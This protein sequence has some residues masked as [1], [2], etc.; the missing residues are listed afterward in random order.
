MKKVLKCP[1]TDKQKQMFIET[2]LEM[3][4]VIKLYHW[5]TKV[6][7]IH[8]ATDDLRVKLEL[9][10]DRFT[11]ILIG[12]CHHRLKNVQQRINLIDI[13][14]TDSLKHKLFEYRG[15]L[16]DMNEILNKKSDTDLLSVRDEIL[17]DINQFLY[18][19]TFDK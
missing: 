3:T 14:T 10:T 8:K 9:N 2:F 1:C 17:G 13:K 11:E 6:Y 4:N 19:L 5:N 12:K 16:V 15:F 18:F 7:S